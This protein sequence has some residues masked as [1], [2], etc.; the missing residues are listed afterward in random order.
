MSKHQKPERPASFFK[1]VLDSVSEHIV[2][3]DRGGIIEYANATW[4]TFG[5][6][7][8]RAESESWQ[9]V[10]YLR[11]CNEPAGGGDQDVRRVKAGIRRVLG[12]ESS[13]FYHEY[14]CPSPDEQRWFLM[15]VTPLRWDGDS[16]FVVSHHDITERKL[17]EGHVH[18]MSRA[19]SL[20]GLANRRHFDEFLASEWRRNSRTGTPLSLM[21]VD[22]DH[23]KRFNDRHGHPA[24][25]D[26]LRRIGVALATLVRRSGD[27]CAR[28][29]GEE[30][31]LILSDTDAEAST[32]MAQTLVRAVRS[33]AI[34]RDN[35]PGHPTVTVSVG[36]AT[37]V[38]Q[39]D[40]SAKML[41]AA[42]DEALYA[43]KNGGR[44]Q[45]CVHRDTTS[46]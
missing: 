35:S 9:G 29:G 26:C 28:Y 1:A 16:L 25:D 17:A 33:A 38:P 24:G 11:A 41:M 34:R 5:I 40:T 13:T 39:R 46:G 15:R 42:A 7:N 27:L 14:P 8:G 3:L 43:A 19:D 37:M 31:A 22:V 32:R 2:I 18:A 44:D 12:G 4:R 30:F 21:M 10:D 36:V 6:A 45:V 23:F 20:T